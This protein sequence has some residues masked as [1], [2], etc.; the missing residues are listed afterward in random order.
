YTNTIH[1]SVTLIKSAFEFIPV[2]ILPLRLLVVDAHTLHT[3]D[4]FLPVICNHAVKTGTLSGWS[5]DANKSVNHGPAKI[6]LPIT[7][8]LVSPSTLTSTRSSCPAP[9]YPEASS[10]CRRSWPCEACVVARS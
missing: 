7:I 5:A 1:S 3:F 6:I 2:V 4:D 10:H 8:H 9:T